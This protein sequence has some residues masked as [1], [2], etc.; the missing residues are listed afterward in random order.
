M[1]DIIA[2]IL[3]VKELR[4]KLGITFLLLVVFRLG[5][6]IPTPGVNVRAITDFVASAQGAVGA[7]LSMADM[8]T[9][10][11][12][13]SMAIFGLGIMPYITA[14]IIFQLLTAI[15]PALSRLAHE[16][17]TGRKKINQYVRASTV[18]LCIVQASML[19]WGMASASGGEG[20][21]YIAPGVAGWEFFLYV[22]FS[23]T[24]GTMF[25]MWLGEQ[26]DE[27]GIGN[28]ISL[29]IMAG[30]LSRIP[31]AVS[32]LISGANPAAGGS[33]VSLGQIV[34]LILLFVAMT[35][36]VV[37]ITLGT[38]R[39]PIMQA[40]AV[41]GRK[42]YG[43][44]RQFLPLKVNQ[45]NVIPII[46]GQ[47]IMQVIAGIAGLIL[48]VY[49]VFMAP[50]SFLYTVL[51]VL[52]IIFFCYFYTAIQFNPNEMADNLKQGG[53]YIPGIRPGKRTAEHLAKI[54]NRIA[55]AGGAFLALI[56]I[57]PQF[58]SSALN[59]SYDISGML[60]GTG[61][62]I[63]VGVALDLVQKV[64]SHLLMRNYEGFGLAGGRI[65]GRRG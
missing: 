30:I 5:S 55:L 53:M 4:V 2:K 52:L 13:S 19:A 63:V 21:S 42:T 50:G 59:V 7:V 28:G 62:L 33:S 23:L 37:L 34:V 6:F 36:A 45:A 43:G 35:L 3:N 39:V 12:L 25:L 64:E 16:G 38:R 29:I 41:R 65:K 46:F 44:Q 31:S 18:L 10:G 26:I 1:F 11:A 57:V 22:V 32:R 61:L 47:A 14:S 17:A 60:G 27:F 49:G 40:K 9:G 24:V 48:G 20:V 54:M 56:A 51:Y 58:I 15:V 8:F